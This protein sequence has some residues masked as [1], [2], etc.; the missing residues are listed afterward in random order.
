[1]Q[2]VTGKTAFITGAGRG[3]GLGMA[4]ARYQI[5]GRRRKLPDYSALRGYCREPGERV[6]GVTGGTPA[7][8]S[9]TLC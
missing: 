9:L 3:M 5:R 4:R 8:S 7:T 2:D 6:P 1:M